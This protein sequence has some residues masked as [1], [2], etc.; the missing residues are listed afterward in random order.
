MIV[1]F[2]VSVMLVFDAATAAVAMMMTAAVVPVVAMLYRLS[3]CAD[4]PS[5]RGRGGSCCS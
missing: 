3:I 2:V 1:M 4:A 5:Q